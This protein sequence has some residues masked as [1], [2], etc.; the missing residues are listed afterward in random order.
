MPGYGGGASQG[1]DPLGNPTPGID[2]DH[3]GNQITPM[4]LAR[5]A[6]KYKRATEEQKQMVRKETHDGYIGCLVLIV[7]IF[8]LLAF[9]TIVA[10][11]NGTFNWEY[12]HQILS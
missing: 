9:A 1:Y 7:L 11:L 12:L 6:V 10:M 5:Q 8:I 4:S 2:W 3:M